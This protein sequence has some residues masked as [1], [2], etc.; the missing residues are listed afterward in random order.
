MSIK[1]VLLRI[2]LINFFFFAFFPKTAYS[3]YLKWVMEEHDVTMEQLWEQLS[4]KEKK[5][6]EDFGMAPD[7]AGSIDGDKVAPS[8]Q[9]PAEN[10]SGNTKEE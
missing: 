3:E 10:I 1:R 5:S 8:V 2:P 9:P 7:D 6:L 4:P